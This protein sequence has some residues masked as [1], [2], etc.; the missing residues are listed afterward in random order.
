MRPYSIDLRERVV[1]AAVSGQTA[2]AVAATFAVSVASVVKWTQRYRKTGNVVPDKQGYQKPLVLA[3][4]R[5]WLLAR[6]AK[7]PDITLRELMAELA[8]RGVKISYYGLWSFFDREN[9]SFKKKPVRQR[10]G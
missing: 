10:A 1:K 5:E 9:I 2:R 8:D 3:G 4:Q 6:V 7:K